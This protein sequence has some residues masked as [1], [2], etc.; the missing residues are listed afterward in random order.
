MP[1]QCERFVFLSS[2]CVWSFVVG[3]IKVQNL[4]LYCK[5]KHF[6]NQLGQGYFR[7]KRESSCS[8]SAG[9]M[10]LAKNDMSHRHLCQQFHDRTVSLCF[11]VLHGMGYLELFTFSAF[12]QSPLITSYSVNKPHNW[13]AISLTNCSAQVKCCMSKESSATSASLYSLNILH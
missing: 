10:V 11:S 5:S 13:Q 4:L 2:V 7:L 8:L 12:C 6:L 3:E 9:L 1:A